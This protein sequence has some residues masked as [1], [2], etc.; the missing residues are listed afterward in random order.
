MEEQRL[1]PFYK[2]PTCIQQPHLVAYLSPNKIFIGG[3]NGFELRNPKTNECIKQE[4]FENCENKKVYDCAVNKAKT[5]FAITVPEK[6]ICY[7]AYTNEKEWE[8]NTGIAGH[9]CLTFHS[10]KDNKVI[11]LVR[12][13]SIFKRLSYVSENLEYI[14]YS[15]EEPIRG[16]M[17][18]HPTRASVRWCTDRRME[19]TDMSTFPCTYDEI[20]PLDHQY[21]PSGRKT[22]MNCLWLKSKVYSFGVDDGTHYPV[23][24]HQLMHSSAV[25]YSENVITVLL[26]DN[27][28]EYYAFKEIL[29]GEYNKDSLITSISLQHITSEKINVY[30]KRIAFSPSGTHSLIAMHNGCCIVQVPFQLVYTED[31]KDK[32]FSIFLLLYN[33]DL[34]LKEKHSTEVT[35]SSLS[36]DIISVIMEKLLPYYRKSLLIG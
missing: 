11:T 16:F 24:M 29:S 8:Y 21:S 14:P 23:I 27:T 10:L 19:T 1:I 18:C 33:N 25:F 6:V 3:Q 20:S 7:N 26:E 4:L 5:K 31:T 32:L 34:T 2:I 13:N 30:G 36:V 12:K 35:Q 22:V 28:L 17:Y 9:S 15:E